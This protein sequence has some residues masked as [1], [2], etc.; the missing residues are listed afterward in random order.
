MTQH[1]L[2]VFFSFSSAIFYPSSLL[3]QMTNLTRLRARFHKSAY[4]YKFPPTQVVYKT[5]DDHV[6][7][8]GA[9][10]TL[11]EALAAAEQLKKGTKKDSKKDKI[12]E[13]SIK[14]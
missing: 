5:N 2:N 12:K 10:V 4:K 13:T 11:H 6:T 8:I 9:G 7:V 3:S 14:V 1:H